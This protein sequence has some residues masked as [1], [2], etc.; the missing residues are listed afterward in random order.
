M[1]ADLPFKCGVVVPYASTYDSFGGFQHGYSLDM[2]MPEGTRLVSPEDGIAYVYNEPNGYGKYIDVHGDSGVIHRL[3]HLQH[4]SV[5]SGA[6]VVRGENIGFVGVSGFTTGPHLHYERRNQ[7]GQI[8]I[9]LDGPALQWAGQQDES[10]FRTTTHALVSGNCSSA[11]G[12][13]HGVSWEGVASS[14]SYKGDRLERG[15]SLRKG[16]YIA[17][18]N[19]RTVL[20]LQ[21]DGNLVIAA[22]GY[23]VWQSGTNGKG[24]D[25]A[26][27]Q[28]DGNFV[29]YD[30]STPI[31]TPI[32]L[33]DFPAGATDYRAAKSSAHLRVQN[34]GN[35]V[36][37][38]VDSP[39][40]TSNPYWWH[41]HTNGMAVEPV[42]IGNEVLRSGERMNTNQYIH[43]LGTRTPHAV[44]LQN[45]GNLVVY[46]PGYHVKWSSGTVHDNVTHVAM[47]HDGNLV[48]Y[49]S[50]KCNGSAWAWQTQT[51][52]NSGKGLFM[53]L[54][55]DG[56]LVVY[57][58]SAGNTAR[59][60]RS[61]SSGARAW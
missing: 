55:D 37:Y 23:V 29:L 32:D 4:T 26:T 49:C 31:W 58:P 38:N 60:A 6:R 20:Y 61:F 27:F 24:V 17:S 2:P 15:E 5:G 40:S 43:N 36:A 48:I 53:R 54:G 11:S 3:A 57:D 18:D 39:S 19:L 1:Y 50:P 46:G 14:A 34:D 59:W 47:Q 56:N 16:E 35:V 12:F 44:L 52:R 28:Y 22:D 41:S 45:D 21:H 30:G 10:G 33:D 9:H 25:R 7:Q 42:N 8:Q 13:V 51:G